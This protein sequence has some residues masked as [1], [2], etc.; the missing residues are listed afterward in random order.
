MIF[1]EDSKSEVGFAMRVCDAHD[2]ISWGERCLKMRAQRCVRRAAMRAAAAR[3]K[4]V[5]GKAL[6]VCRSRGRGGG[7]LAF[8]LGPG[9][10]FAFALVGWSFR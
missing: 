3:G 4:R 9:L 6:R 2:F 1:R 5:E 7:I 8:A 10:I